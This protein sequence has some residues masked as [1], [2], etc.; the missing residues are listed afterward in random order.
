MASES[1]NKIAKNTVYLYIRQG[2]GIIIS[3]LTVGV[4]LDVLGET[5]YGINSLVAGAVSM[6]TFLTGAMAIGNERFYAY[7]L[8]KGDFTKLRRIF[9]GT[10]T[11][12]IIISI[13]LFI[14]GETFGLWLL[15]NQLVIPPN[16][17]HAANI[18]FQ[19]GLINLCLSLM[20]PP[21]T[22]LITAHED[23]KFFAKMSLWDATARLGTIAL[24][25]F[26]PI[27]KLI[28]TG[29]I[30]LG[31]S[32]IGQFINFSFCY[33]NYPECHAKPMYE[34]SILKELVGF[35]FWNLCGNFAWMIK[36]QGTAFLLNMFFGPIVNAAQSISMGVRG[37]SSMFAGSFMAAMVPQITKNYANNNY[38]HMFKLAFSGA[39]I[40]FMLMAIIVIPAI[41]NIEFALNL[42]LP[43][44]PKYAIPFCQII[45]IEVLF[46]QTSGFLATINQA[47]GK[48]KK[49]QLLIG[50]YGCLNLPVAY[51]ALK[52][53]SSAEYVFVIS[54]I[55]Q[56][57]VIGVR[58]VFLKRIDPSSQMRCLK[59]L[60]FPCLISGL[61]AALLCYFI[62]S[63][64]K[65]II[66][67]LMIFL[68]VI[69]VAVTIFIVAFNQEE[70]KLCFNYILKFLSKLTKRSTETQISL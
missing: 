37:M 32:L 7:Y 69:I 49:Y 20:M 21:F 14:L 13:I 52:L 60:I 47:T 28:A 44:I 56:L 5:D 38:D 11:L 70:K 36:N 15:N 6:F 25:Y 68:E 48:I 35:N 1:T 9:Q 31:I 62:P 45:L 27:D 23:M 10:L 34:K 33:K 67:L 26:A 42:W 17:I 46:E 43:S 61:I 63:N 57:F 53:G 29:I 16:R 18:L 58:V 51:I 2:I 4:T 40:V 54:L 66:Q 12:Y 59:K 30:G 22:A 3:F 24:L 55:L 64:D 39:K 19:L 8:G 41:F 65:F 50:F